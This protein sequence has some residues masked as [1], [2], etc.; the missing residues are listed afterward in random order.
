LLIRERKNKTSPKPLASKREA[1]C[2]FKS[3]TLKYCF[4]VTFVLKNKKPMFIV[5]ACMLTGITVGY[6]MRGWKIRFIHKLILSLIW[7]LLFLLG[8]EVG[9]NDSV[10]HHFTGLG[11]QA[12]LIAF[13]STSGSVLGAWL[14]G[15]NIKKHKNS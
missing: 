2:L 4:F 11:F 8:I 3:N 5:I 13:A 15:L 12:F 1:L 14:L 6:L 9:L 10:I 7:L